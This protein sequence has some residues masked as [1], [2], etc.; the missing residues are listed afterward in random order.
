[1]HGAANCNGDSLTFSVSRATPVI[2]AQI[3]KRRTTAER[4]YAAVS[5][6]WRLANNVGDLGERERLR[7]S[8]RLEPLDT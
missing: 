8:G 7:L 3:V 5:W 4:N 1:V 6:S 2:L